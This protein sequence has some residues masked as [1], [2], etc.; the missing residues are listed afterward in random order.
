MHEEMKN[1]RHK[2]HYAVRRCKKLA[3]SVRAHNLF[4]AAQQGDIDLLKEMKKIQG[5][6]KQHAA[7]PDNIDDANGSAQICD[8]FKAVYEEL[9]N[10]AGSEEP[11]NEIKEKLNSIIGQESMSDVNKVTGSVLKEACSRM[12]PGKTDVSESFTSDILLHAP[13][14]LFE[15]LAVIFR[16]FLVHGNVTLELLSCA[17]L[18]LFKGGLKNPNMSDSYRAIAGS[19]Q[20]LKLLDNVILLLWGDLLNSDSLQFGF[21]KGT[22][23][24]QCSWLVMEV[25]SYYLRQGTPVIATLL[26]CSKAFDKCQFSTLFT[27]LM[28]K[29]M[30]PIV[31]RMQVCVYEEQRGCVKWDGVRSSAFSIVNGTRQGSVLSPTLFSVYLDDLLK[32]LRLM[33]LGCHVGG[34]WVGAAGYADDLI[35]LAPSRSAMKQMLRVCE[36]NA[37]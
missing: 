23:T 20:I 35:L 37:T 10:S 21:K 27:K 2:Y 18:P 32:Q 5:G 3:D 22:S 1:A 7:C 4:E 8:M 15:C 26:D 36:E 16:S 24:T 14:N 12:K 19:S 17:F 34:V 33:G 29:G 13:D 28:E 9:Y 25:A 31:T 30:P 11:M 6:K